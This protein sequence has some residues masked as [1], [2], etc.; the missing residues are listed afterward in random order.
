MKNI[1]LKTLDVGYVYT[2][3]EPG[4]LYDPPVYESVRI[5][6][7]FDPE[8]GDILEE[9]GRNTLKELEAEVLRRHKEERYA[10]AN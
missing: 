1:R 8:E 9:L 6:E 3:P 10:N 4:T 7:V 2:P 5:E